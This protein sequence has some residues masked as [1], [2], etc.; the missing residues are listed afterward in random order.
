MALAAVRRPSGDV[1]DH[2]DEL[3]GGVSLSAGELDQLVNLL[4]DG[5]AFGRAGHGD[6][7]AAAKF[8]QSFRPGV[9]AASAGRC[10]C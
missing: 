4:H 5:A 8:E 3:V 1:V 10:S 6:A 7:A 9:A 2:L